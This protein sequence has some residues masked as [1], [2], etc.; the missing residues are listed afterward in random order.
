MI[1]L[2]N[3]SGGYDGLC[4]LKDISVRISETGSITT[5]V[6]PNGCGKSTLLRMMAGLK[7]P[8]EGTVSLQG[9]DIREYESRELAQVVSFLPQTRD[10]PRIPA[11]S[12]VLHG[13]FPYVGYPRRYKEE[14][15]RKA[16]KAMEWV[17]IAHL[18][19]R[20]V[21]QLSGGE[22]QKVYLAMM[23][24]QETP[25]VLLDE[26]TSYLDIGCKFEVLDLAIRMKTEGKTVV[27]VLHD[28]DLA[29]TYSDRIL[30]MRGGQ[31][32]SDGTPGEIYNRGILESV[33]DV[34]VRKV[35]TDQEERYIFRPGL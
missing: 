2:T 35:E 29:L 5:I 32:V 6:G 24:A 11:G 7:Q 19:E 16:R 12:L 25:V 10:V 8:Y 1:E 3:V 21:S 13:R 23:L 33:F 20:M 14:D 15:R 9:R 22:R 18:A 34:R 26:P 27:L 4:L 31:M 30:V 17:G 28:L